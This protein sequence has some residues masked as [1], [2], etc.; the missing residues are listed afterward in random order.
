MAN[1]CIQI[2]TT[3]QK[4]R[5]LFSDGNIYIQSVAADIT[6]KLDLEGQVLIALIEPG[7][8]GV[9]L[10]TDKSGYFLYKT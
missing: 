10:N 9:F 4:K 8:N 7:S 2:I 5:I 1:G 3:F 6:V